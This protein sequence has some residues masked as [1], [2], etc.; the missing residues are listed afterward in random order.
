MYSPW[1]PDLL[2]LATSP[3]PWRSWS[4]DLYLL[5]FE[6]G[7]FSVYPRSWLSLYKRRT[8]GLDLECSGVMARSK[9]I[10]ATGLCFLP[11]AMS[12]GGAYSQVGCQQIHV[13]LNTN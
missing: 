6:D 3:K 11:S 5:L 1:Q 9:V 12:Q 10:L 4:G 7:I 8:P 13:K 2:L